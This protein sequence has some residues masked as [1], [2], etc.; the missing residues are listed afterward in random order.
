MGRHRHLRTDRQLARWV[1]WSVALLPLLLLLAI[2]L[3][4]PRHAVASP[5]QESCA[6]P[7]AGQHIYD[8]AHLLSPD[9]T[10]MLEARAAAVDRAGA[11][12]IVYLQARNASAEQAL[13][14]AI[15][16][17]TRWGVESRPGVRDGFVMFF[18]L[19]PGNL[20]HGQVALYAGAKH[21][22]H[23]NLPISELTRIRTDVMTPLLTNG[24]TA[25]GIAAGLQMVASDLKYGPPP[26]PAYRTVSA[27][28]GRIPINALA[29]LY[30]AVV[31]L[32]WMRLARRAPMGS[33]TMSISPDESGNIPPALAGALVKGRVT[34]IQIEATILDFARRGMLVM[35]PTAKDKVR[36]RL[37]SDGKELVGYER[38][39]W[40][41]LAGRADS[42]H[43]LSGDDL[44][45]LRQQWSWS[46]SLLTRE[47]AERSWYDPA[48]ASARRRPLYSA[49]A[50]SAV[51]AV[52]AIVL[53]VLSREGWAAMSLLLFLG[54]GSAAFVLAYMVPNTTVEGQLAASSW[55]AYRETVSARAYEPNLDTDLP[56]IVALGLVGKLAPRLKAASERG[57]APSWFHARGDQYAGPGH[58]QGHYAGGYGFYPYWIVFHGSMAPPSSGAGGGSASGGYSGGGAAGGGGGSAGSF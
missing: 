26:P 24:Q 46:K 10:S 47:L 4:S 21:S 50:L 19:Q 37:L 9:E 15:D 42:A 16:L 22:Q 35:E 52:A 7:V 43:A 39:V 25:E 53:I 33:E 11:P 31:A 20:R 45:K 28:I 27:T 8:C 2:A 1:V 54:A 44:A 56:Y 23:G 34:D 41:G 12:T 48:G 18:D 55:R 30:V 13:Q 51:G 38:E 32:L 17:M 40:N 3:A 58:Y 29:V 5:A 49:G 6:G 36:V 57:Y 14:D